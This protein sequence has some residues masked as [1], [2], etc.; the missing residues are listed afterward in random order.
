[1]VE[2]DGSLSAGRIVIKALEYLKSQSGELSAHLEE[3]SG[4]TENE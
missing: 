1:V 4:V 3:L 2:S